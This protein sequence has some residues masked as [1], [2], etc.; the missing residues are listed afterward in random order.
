VPKPHSFDRLGGVEQLVRLPQVPIIPPLPT[1]PTVPQTS[2]SSAE[3]SLPSAAVLKAFQNAKTVLL[4]GHENPDGD[5]IGAQA[6][7][8]RVLE[9]MGKTVHILNP[10]PPEAVFDY[11]S[12]EVAYGTFQGGDLPDHDLCVLTDISELGRCGALSGP[13]GAHPSTKL[14]VDHHVHHG[15]EWWDLA[16]VD[17]TASATGLLVYR[18]AKA[19]GVELDTVAANG[20]FTSLVT[21]TGWFKYSNT[22]AETLRI[23]G[24]MI[25]LGVKSDRLYASIF[26]RNLS[27]LPVELGELLRGLEYFGGG[28]IALLAADPDH[29]PFES[30]TDVLHDIL[31]SVEVVEVVLFLRQTSDGRIKLSAR[32]KNDW[33]VNALAR[34]FG[35]GGHVKASGATLQGPMDRARSELLEAAL[36]Q[37][38]SEL[39]GGA[40]AR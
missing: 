9:A 2:Q 4:S 8:A 12:C 22:D 29:G 18:L 3:T 17:R 35:G 40:V 7:L 16:Y 32:S 26:Q 23:A 28:K 25:G 20:V 37:Y 24:E 13:L 31:R 30:N 10:D 33:N 36:E 14:V 15:E 39:S 19:L 6:A 27:A 38:A 11:L 5:C 21:D 1:D 34:R